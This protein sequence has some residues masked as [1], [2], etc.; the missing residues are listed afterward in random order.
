MDL[1]QI[2]ILI[3]DD[4]EDL[5]EICVDTFDMEGFTVFSAMNGV[6]ALKVLEE[7]EGIAVVISDAIM[8]EM[9][10]HKLLEEIKVK[11]SDKAPLFYFS[12]GAMDVTEEELQAKGAK[13]LVSKP[14]NLDALVDRIK[15]D[16]KL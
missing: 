13:G 12:T 10:G 1:S 14:Y 3:V 9:D 15:T 8:P 6:E 2:K 4:E 11:Y 5:I 16:L 7:Q